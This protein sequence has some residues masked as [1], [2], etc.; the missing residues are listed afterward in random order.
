[1]QSLSFRQ[2][3]PNQFYIP[4]RGGDPTFRLLL[5]RVQYV[6]RFRKT[7][8]V[9]GSPGVATM[10]SNDLDDGTSAKPAHGLR[11]RIDL[12]I[13]R[14]VESSADVAA[15]LARKF[16][17]VPSTRTDPYDRALHF[18]HNTYIRLLV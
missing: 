16:V 13:L 10:M 12:T 1:M 8:G 14:G 7:N 2:T 11:R 17:Q 18:T 15:D 5:E 6:N 4:F 9:H 3:L